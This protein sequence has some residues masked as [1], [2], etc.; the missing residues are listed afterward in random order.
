MTRFHGPLTDARLRK[1]LMEY[2]RKASDMRNLLSW[3]FGKSRVK[4]E[5]SPWDRRSEPPAALARF[6]NSEISSSI[7]GSLPEDPLPREPTAPREKRYD[8]TGE[9]EVYLL[10][11]RDASSEPNDQRNGR[12]YQG[13]QD[14]DG[15]DFPPP[16]S[17]PGIPGQQKSHGNGWCY[18]D[19]PPPPPRIPWN[20]EPREEKA[21][22]P[23]GCAPKELPTCALSF[24]GRT[25]AP[26]LVAPTPHLIRTRRSPPTSQ[27]TQRRQSNPP[28]DSRGPK[29]PPDWCSC[30][31]K[32]PR[33]EKY[34]ARG[35]PVRR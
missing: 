18:E 12:L 11:D 9:Q 21:G 17:S 28:R 35:R 30:K 1:I 32:Q 24:H 34:P 29:A 25:S 10:A 7:R 8:P 2:D 19:Q 5:G 26:S 31:S 6:T 16:W 20:Q 3:D 4:V 22:E 13:C 14:Y 33:K 27:R 23:E 15:C